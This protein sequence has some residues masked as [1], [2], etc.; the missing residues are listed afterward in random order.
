MIIGYNR[1]IVT[2][3]R[4]PNRADNGPRN[5][6]QKAAMVRKTNTVSSTEKLHRA[7]AEAAQIL[8]KDLAAYS[9]MLR[10]YLEE[11]G[12]ERPV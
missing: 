3:P 9:A 11:A 4:S 6:D 10:L 5:Q 2:Y 7:S 8:G 12:E 1:Y